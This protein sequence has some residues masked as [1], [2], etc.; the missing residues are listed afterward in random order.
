MRSPT[1]SLAPSGLPT[2]I[3]TAT[4]EP[5]GL[6]LPN[7]PRRKWR[8]FLLLGIEPAQ[9]MRRPIDRATLGVARVGGPNDPSIACRTAGVPALFLHRH[10]CR[11]D[12]PLR[13]HPRHPA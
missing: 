5:A 13:L 7:L 2:E 9:R 4:C 3:P 6:H 1:L 11:R 8:G 10:R 12:L